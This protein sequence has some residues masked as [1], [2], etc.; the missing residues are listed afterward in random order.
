MTTALT[1]EEWADALE[2]YQY[3]YASVAVVRREHA[4][5]WLDAAAVMFRRASDPRG[6]LSLDPD[7]DEPERREDPLF[8]FTQAPRTLA[9]AAR[10]RSR[11]RELP[12][13][14]VPSL[15]VLLGVPGLDV[16]RAPDFDGDRPGMERRARLLLSRFTDGTR[17]YS[18]VGWEGDQPDFYE[19]PVRQTYPFSRYGWDAGLIAVN[20]SELALLWHFDPT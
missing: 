1:A 17:F 2:L 5:W 8:P 9:E 3:S 20:D 7:E 19:Q 6:W 16:T 14:S 10:F 18:N 15:L 12:R 4:E 13:S 11:V